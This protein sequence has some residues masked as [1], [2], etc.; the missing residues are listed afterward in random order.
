[1]GNHKS[2]MLASNISSALEHIADLKDQD[3]RCNAEAILRALRVQRDQP[4]GHAPVGIAARPGVLAFL[5]AHGVWA[6]HERAGASGL[7]HAV[8]VV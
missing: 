7:R 4:M 8:V 1:M 3:D 6:Y 5:R 2:H